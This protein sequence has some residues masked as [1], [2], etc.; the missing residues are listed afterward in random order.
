MNRAIFTI[1]YD[2]IHSFYRAADTEL[3][4]MEEA[5]ASILTLE[6]DTWMPDFTGEAATSIKG[7]FTEVYSSIAN[8]FLAIFQEYRTVLCAYIQSFLEDIDGNENAILS[9]ECME[10]MKTFVRDGFFNLDHIIDEV[11][12]KIAG[13][14]D[15]LEVERM[16]T[17]QMAESYDMVIH[18]TTKAIEDIYALDQS[19]TD[20]E[21]AHLEQSIANLKA[22][23]QSLQ[24]QR[25]TP[26]LENGQSFGNY[27]RGDYAKREEYLA[28]QKSEL[29]ILEYY[30]ENADKLAKGMEFLNSKTEAEYIQATQEA[31]EMQRN[32]LKDCRWRR[33]LY[34]AIEEKCKAIYLMR[35]L[36]VHME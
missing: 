25:A 19:F 2:A 5:L 12:E 28:V 1:D 18:K 24:N 6:A 29:D 22:Y 34:M 35:M 17:M 30:Q 14:S 33:I 21:I 16:D 15:I 3:V 20:N 27:Q 26:S 4:K 23:I 7:Y 36:R 8:A 10:S 13:I 9:E 32:Y 31:E 11:N